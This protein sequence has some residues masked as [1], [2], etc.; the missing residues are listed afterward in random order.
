MH[1]GEMPDRRLVV[2]ELLRGWWRWGRLHLAR[3]HYLAGEE[4]GGVAVVVSE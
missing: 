3:N 1:K 4:W 2:W